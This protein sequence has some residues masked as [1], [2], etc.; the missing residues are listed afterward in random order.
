MCLTN[1]NKKP[2]DSEFPGR[3]EGPTNQP[4]NQPKWGSDDGAED[5]GGLAG[6]ELFAE[7]GH[8]V[9]IGGLGLGTEFDLDLGVHHVRRLG[10]EK[11]V[12]GVG[13]GATPLDADAS[14]EGTEFVTGHRVE[15]GEGSG[16]EDGLVRDHKRCVF[17]GVGANNRH[18]FHLLGT[19]YWEMSGNARD[20][21]K[22]FLK[23]RDPEMRG[24]SSAINSFVKA[25]L[26]FFSRVF[27][28][29]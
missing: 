5:L 26:E 19:I 15:G 1:R 11:V 24:K 13:A 14:G 2:R 8:P 12:D 25:D 17:V 21:L 20:F 10:E 3:T 27:Q 28:A 16:T 23:S 22:N 6:G 18:L 9:G 4:T 7:D 29:L